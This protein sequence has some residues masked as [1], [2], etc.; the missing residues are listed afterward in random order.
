MWVPACCLD[1]SSVAPSSASAQ[2]NHRL[3]Q[4][5]VPLFEFTIELFIVVY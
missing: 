1:S 5:S 4:H 3:H 2:A